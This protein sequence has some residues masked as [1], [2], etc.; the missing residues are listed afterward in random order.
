M[1]SILRQPAP[2]A[3]AHAIIVEEL[4]SQLDAVAVWL[5]LAHLPHVLFLDSAG[6]HAGL[7]R[8]SFV[9]ADPFDWLWS[10][11]K[12]VNARGQ[13]QRLSLA[14]PFAAVQERLDRCRV[15]PRPELPPFPGGAAGLFGYDLCHHLERLPRPAHDDFAV[16]DLAIGFY[17]WAVGFDHEAERA[18]LVSTGLPETD[19][20]RRR[21]R[22]HRRLAQVQE[23]LQREPARV[24]QPPRAS[25]KGL[26]PQFPLRG[27][28]DVTS[29]FERDTYLHTVRRAIEYIHA[30]DCFQVNLA[31]RLLHPAVESPIALYR[32]LRERNPAPFAGYFDFGDFVIASASPE[33]FLRV[34]SAGRQQMASGGRQPPDR[35]PPDE[36]ETRPI[37]G[38]RP[39]G[40]T[41]A[42]DRARREELL[43]SPKDR[44]ENVMIVD[45][46]RNDLGRVCRYGSVQVESLCRLE[47]FQYVHH[48]VSEV[49]GRLRPGLGPIDLLRAAFPGGSVTGAPKIR[50]MEIIAE[51]EP[52]ARGPYCGSLGYFGFDGSM[53]TNL[54]IRTFTVGKGWV[55]F[56]VGGG[57]VA[58][59]LPEQEY[60]ETW[61]KA[62]GMLRALNQ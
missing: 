31:Q 1:G 15:E 58:D 38:T 3:D 48:L 29:S 6:P 23:W 18:W 55:Q 41:P 9:T 42:E 14:D 2:I 43:A 16:P 47:S 46:L 33:R 7:G 62:E 57:I 11:G 54:L 21:R 4:P 56:C 25:P 39:R 52:T 26:A 28:R 5:R 32:R 40:D 59:S 22:A 45:L 12:S 30:G 8:F 44:A 13:T 61:H 24:P 36:V 60:E 35:Q 27:L 51:L 37:K 20:R 19:P 17:D 53:D 50:A 34:T 49:R 10:R